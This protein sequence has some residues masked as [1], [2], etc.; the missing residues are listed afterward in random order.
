MSEP[1]R[2]AVTR[3]QRAGE[4]MRGDP[5][6]AAPDM[7]SRQASRYAAA[8]LCKRG[9]LPEDASAFTAIWSAA[10]RAVAFFQDGR[11]A[12][13]Y[14]IPDRVMDYDP[15]APARETRDEEEK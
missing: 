11:F 12:A 15:A 10:T 4:I 14:R 5:R 7:M 1:V 9:L 13:A 3:E 6:I 8:M 2:A